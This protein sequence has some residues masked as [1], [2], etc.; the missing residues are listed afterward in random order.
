[1]KKHLST[2]VGGIHFLSLLF[3]LQEVCSCVKLSGFELKFH[4]MLLVLVS[5][6]HVLQELV[7]AIRGRADPYIAIFPLERMFL[8]LFKFVMHHCVLAD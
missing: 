5:P 7:V 1:M 3:T 2:S 8:A 4:A 6:L